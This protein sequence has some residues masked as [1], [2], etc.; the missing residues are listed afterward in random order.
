MYYTGIDPRNG[1]SVFVA[2]DPEEK[3]MQRALIQYSLPENY[4][5]VK[6]ALI[7]AKREDLIGDSAD[8]LIKN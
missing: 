5:L 1:E 4:E 2:K 7:K 6:R 3:R 8:C